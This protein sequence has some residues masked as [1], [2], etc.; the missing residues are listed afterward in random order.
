MHAATDKTPSPPAVPP[1]HY[2]LRT[3]VTNPLPDRR[4]RHRMDCAATWKAGEVVRVHLNKGSADAGT[5]T[6]ADDTSITFDLSSRKPAGVRASRRWLDYTHGNALLGML[7]PAPPSLGQILDTYGDDSADRILA[8]LLDD[9]KIGLFDVEEAAS[10]D[11]APGVPVG[12][13]AA[14]APVITA[15][16]RRHGLSTR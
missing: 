11:V 14:R 12:D 9:G 2:R 13:H 15:F 5:I 1:G 4:M 8:I 6:F 16:C 7:E 3:D 10:R